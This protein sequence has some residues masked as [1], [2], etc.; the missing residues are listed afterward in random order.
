[1]T[2][3][4]FMECAKLINGNTVAI[5]EMRRDRNPHPDFYDDF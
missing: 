5:F 1:M 2:D 4:R 3:I